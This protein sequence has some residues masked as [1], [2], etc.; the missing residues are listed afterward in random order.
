MKKRNNLLRYVAVGILFCVVCVVYVGRLIYLQVAGQDYYTMSQPIVRVTR[1]VPI[2][3][4][5]G[6]IYDTN[7]VPLVTNRYSYDLQLEYSSFPRSESEK[8]AMVLGLLEASVRH[9]CTPL[10]NGSLPI[11]VSGVSGGTSGGLTVSF[12][13]DFF[14]YGGARYRRFAALIEGLYVDWGHEEDARPASPLLAAM[15]AVPYS[16]SDPET[17]ET[18][19]DRMAD[20]PPVNRC[21]QALLERYG[22][23]TYAD[24]TD[25]VGQLT[26]SPEDTVTLLCRRLDME[27]SDFSTAAPYTLFEDIPLS[28]V[29]HAEES[30]H[31]GIRIHIDAARQYEFPGYASHILGSVGKLD[32]SDVDYYT[33]QGYAMDAIVGKSGVEAAFE[34]YLRGVDGVLTITED[35]AGNVI[36]TE[37]TTQPI[38]GHNVYLTID[39]G[40]QMA[41]EIALAQN[42]Q[43]IREEA[44]PD[45]PMSGEDASAGALVAV[46]VDTGA[47]LAIASYPTYNLA[48]LGR[49]I[50][51]LRDDETK[52]ML[53]RAIQSAFAPGSTFK[54]GVAVAALENEIIE[55]DTIINAQGTYTVYE[56]YQPSCWVVAKGGAHGK[57]SVVE[58]IQESCNYFF[59]EVGRLLTIEKINDRMSTFGLGQSTGIELY[60]NKGILAGP[61]YRDENGLDK[62]SP[63]D[64][65]QAA[66]G[67][68]DNLFTPLQICMYT[69]T[70]LNKGVRYSAHLLDRVS[71]YEGD[72][73]FEAAP[74]VL[75]DKPISDEICEI[76]LEGMKNVMDN[77]SAARIFA[78]YPITVGG[79][80]GTA[81]V[82]STKSDNAIMTAFA[83][84]E[85]PDI[86]VTCVIEQGYSGTK[87]GY[88]IKDV[89]DYYFGLN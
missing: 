80:T 11:V 73:L 12:R 14:A 66:I 23:I 60:E 36:S 27:L 68:S 45:N 64:T 75:E 84:Y 18:A 24:R 76:V 4:I 15:A 28:M 74:A 87:A 59:F 29:A 34:L 54:V 82:Y 8:N 86:A 16:G 78:G 39:I 42:V 71:V 70:L 83:P 10:E 26:H 17:A 2:Q 25:T 63:G 1:T 62:W 37:V 65:L 9:D 6:E 43:Q 33:E 49:D 56:D 32:R 21:V 20:F 50:V 57:I 61:D 72:V 79:K 41:A 19:A 38:A 67:Q 35:T 44:D 13:E 58:A 7:G 40:M 52:P 85:N 46:K 88:S 77:G 3:A 89:F 81:Q 5:R 47:V 53:N 55:K 69:T 48:T 22:L 30:W 31:R 51:I